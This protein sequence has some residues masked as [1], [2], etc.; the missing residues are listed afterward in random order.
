MHTQTA[1]PQSSAMAIALKQAGIKTKRQQPR[2]ARSSDKPAQH[3]QVLVEKISLD[4]GQP[5]RIALS[6]PRRLVPRGIQV[7]PTSGGGKASGPAS[8]DDGRRRFRNA[9]IDLDGLMARATV[10]RINVVESNGF[11][12]VYLEC[13]ST[14]GGEGFKPHWAGTYEDFLRPLLERAWERV[15]VKPSAP[16]FLRL[17]GKCDTDITT[18]LHFAIAR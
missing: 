18:K 6:V 4:N 5:F 17:R 1:Q 11:C 2:R 8:G 13:T 10:N 9:M 14:A 7:L 3:R 15:T 12:T 16:A